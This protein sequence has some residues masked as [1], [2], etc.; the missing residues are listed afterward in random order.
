MRVRS[1][2]LRARGRLRAFEPMGD[3]AG[4]ARKARRN[5][6]FEAERGLIIR[7]YTSDER[8]AWEMAAA[9]E[10]GWEILSHNVVSKPSLLFLALFFGFFSNQTEHV[11]TFAKR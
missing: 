6:W 8:A 5:P 10:R 3:D 11:I 4:V 2:E 7:R 1:E 9:L